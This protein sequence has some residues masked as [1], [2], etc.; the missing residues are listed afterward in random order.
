MKRLLIP[1]VISLVILSAPP[2]EAKGF[3][4]KVK[5]AVYA[6]SS[7]RGVLRKVLGAP[8]WAI[9]FTVTLVGDITVVP[10]YNGAMHYVNGQ[11]VTGW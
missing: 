4:K 11:S 6:G 10:L 2:A 3:W 9:G 7:D 1:M 5:S 8:F